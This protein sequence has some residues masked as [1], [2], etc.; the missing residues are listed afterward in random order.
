MS[1][2]DPPLRALTPSRTR[3]AAAALLALAV[4][5]AGCWSSRAGD[6]AGSSRFEDRPVTVQVENQNWNTVHVYVVAGGQFQSL[7]QISSQST[8]TYEVT[9]GMLGSRKEIRLMADPVGSRESFL[10]DPILIEPGDLVE[11]TLAQPLV[12]SR[13]MVR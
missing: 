1:S 12:H 7:G 10:T 6:D 11:W 5:T 4:A 3:S 13:I 8:A 2:V 9:A